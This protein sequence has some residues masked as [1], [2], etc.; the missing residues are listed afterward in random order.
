MRRFVVSVVLLSLLAVSISSLAEAKVVAHISLSAQRMDVSV[1]GVPL[2][3]WRVSTARA[4]YR[5]GKSRVACD[6]LL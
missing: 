6:P 2:Y 1:N 5:E 4:G 3:S